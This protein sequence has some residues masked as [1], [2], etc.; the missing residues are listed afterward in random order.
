MSETETTVADWLTFMKAQQEKAVP[1]SLYKPDSFII[2][3]WK[4]FLTHERF[5][6]RPIVSITYQQALA[7]CAWRS[8]AT[9]AAARVKNPELPAM[10]YRLPTPEEWTA[11]AQAAL[12]SKDFIEVNQPPAPMGLPVLP[13][14]KGAKNMGG[15]YY[16]L[17][18]VAEMTS[19]HGIAKGGSWHHGPS[20]SAPSAVIPYTRTSTWLGFRCVVEYVNP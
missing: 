1:D 19:K 4:G 9:T 10:R 13:V 5:A 20:Q 11:V 16:L 15:F 7:Y 18:N 14:R 6:D 12:G 17:G 8:Q 2:S 3:N